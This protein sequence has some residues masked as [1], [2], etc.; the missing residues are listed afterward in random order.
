MKSE[1]LQKLA[2]YCAYQERC[3]WE[4]QVKLESFSVLPEE[5][6]AYLDW[7]EDNN[8]LNQERFAKLFVR[9]KFNQKSWGRNKIKFELTRLQIKDTLIQSALEE[10]KELPYEATLESILIDK[11]NQVK[12]VNDWTKKQKCYQYAM[13]KGFE[14]DLI[15][16]YIQQFR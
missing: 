16:L 8:Y 6:A 2:R 1:I 14:S 9:S 11:F 3:V 12:D 15:S 10:L 7:L 4:I 5:Q 13:R